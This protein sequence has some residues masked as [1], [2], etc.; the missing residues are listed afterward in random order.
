MQQN[1]CITPPIPPQYHHSRQ[2]TALIQLPIDA[3]AS[4]K[5]PGEDGIPPEVIECGKPA[6][7]EPLHELLFLCWREGKVPQDMRNAKIITLY[8][9]KGDRSDCNNYQDISLLSIIDKVFAG[10]VLVRLQVL[11]ERIYP[12]SQC[13]LQEQ[14]VHSGHDLLYSTAPG[15]VPRATNASLHRPHQGI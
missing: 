5:A 2:H 12:D 1:H 13:G 10:R 8:K 3:L 7:L 9:N 6:L 15:E 4:G 14:E 11:A